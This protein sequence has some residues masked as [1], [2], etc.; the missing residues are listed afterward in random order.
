MTYWGSGGEGALRQARPLSQMTQMMTFSNAPSAPPCIL[1]A[2]C[3]PLIVSLSWGNQP[4]VILLCLLPSKALALFHHC[5]VICEEAGPKGV[6]CWGEP[7][8][9]WARTQ[10]PSSRVLLNPNRATQHLPLDV[11][12]SPELFSSSQMKLCIH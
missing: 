1:H 6:G 11:G 7:L 8:P 4:W 3:T 2:H 10:A 12:S 5:Y 9:Q